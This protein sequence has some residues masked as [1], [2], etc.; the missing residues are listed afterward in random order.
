M[1]RIL[2]AAIAFAAAF[3]V[4]A[5]MYAQATAQ[6]ESP[7]AP[8]AFLIGEWR[9]DQIIQRFSWGPSNSYITYSTSILGD[10]GVEHL[11]FE[12][13][14][15]FNAASRRLDYLF[16]VEP[17]SSG[18]E[19]GE[20]YIGEDGAV[21]RDVTLTNGSGQTNHFRQTFRASGPDAAITSLM[22]QDVDG[23]W[24]PNFPGSDRL[25]MT[26]VHRSS[27]M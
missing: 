27:A 7:Y 26:R 3:A 23:S 16:V 21:V 24:S 18:Q 17:G 22:R 25:T 11:H 4:S 6:V 14:L 15:V 13:I 10:G 2:C 5:P 20:V 12:G 9:S 19:Q 8:Y 1:K